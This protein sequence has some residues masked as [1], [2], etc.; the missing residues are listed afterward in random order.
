MHAAPA[1]VWAQRWCVAARESNF[2]YL[3]GAPPTGS[4]YAM[5]SR[6]QGL[7]TQLQNILTTP[8]LNVQGACEC[9]GEGETSKVLR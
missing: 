6:K 1:E 3:L 9:R 5:V 7:L 8:C 2:P 4:P